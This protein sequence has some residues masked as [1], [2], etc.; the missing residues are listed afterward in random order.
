M[1]NRFAG[2]LGLDLKIFPGLS[3]RKLKTSASFAAF[4]AQRSVPLACFSSKVLSEPE[5]MMMSGG[6]AEGLADV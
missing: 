5:K 1:L 2:P 4:H 6:G 3:E